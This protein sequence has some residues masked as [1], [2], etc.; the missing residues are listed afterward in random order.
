MKK[1]ILSFSAFL[2]LNFTN[3]I[4]GQTYN[5]GRIQLK[6]WLHKVWSS[7]D[8]SEISGADPV[9]KNI[10]VRV[11]T[12]NSGTYDISPS[13]LDIYFDDVG[14][15][16]WWHMGQVDNANDG[17]FLKEDVNN[18]G[19]LLFNKTYPSSIVP[20]EFQWRLDEMY[21]KDLCGGDFTYRSFQPNPFSSNFCLDG[22]DNYTSY[23]QWQT[24]VNPFRSTPAGEIGY[25]QTD[26]ADSDGGGLFGGSRDD[27]YALIFA[28]EWNWVTP[29]PPMCPSSTYRDGPINVQVRIKGVWSDS[30]YDGGINCVG[31]FAGQEELRIRTR[32]RD[33]ATNTWSS[34]ASAPNLSQP[35]P[36]WN[37]YGSPFTIFNET[38]NNNFTSVDIDFELWE[39]DGCGPDNQYNTCSFPSNA[40]ND[41]EHH[42]TGLKTIKWRDS[43]PNTW[44][45]VDFPLRNGTGKFNNWTIWLEYRWNIDPPTA[46]IDNS[47]NFGS[48][49]TYVDRILCNTT[50]T[51]ISATTEHATYYQW[52][53]ANVTG[54]ET[55][56]SGTCPSGAVWSNAPGASTCPDYVPP[57]TPGTRIYRLKVMNRSGS[58]STTNSGNRLNVAYSECVRVTYLPYAPPIVSGIC[59]GN[60]LT[61]STHVFTVKLPD[62][63]EGVANVNYNWSVSPSSN[64]SIS[65]GSTSTAS[66]TFPTPTQVLNGGNYT[67]TLTTSGGGCSTA[68]RT[69]N[70]TV[71]TEPVCNI[72]VVPGGTGGGTI[73]DPAGLEYALSIVTS[74]KN[75]IILRNGTYNLTGSA[76]TLNI[77]SHTILDG[78]YEIVGGVWRKNSN[79][80][81]TINVLGAQTT[82]ASTHHFVAANIDGRTNVYIKDL[83]ITNTRNASGTASNRGKS[84]YGVRVANSNNFHFTR[85]RINSG[86]ASNGNNGGG[87]STGSG[88]SNAENG[89]NGC[90]DCNR[91]C[92][93]GGYGGR[94]GTGGGGTSPGA[95]R[96]G[97]CGSNDQGCNGYGGS[98]GS[99][100]NGGGGGGGGVGG[101]E[102][103][104]SH[105]GGNGG[106]G[107]TGGGPGGNVSTG[108]T[109]GRGEDG[110]GASN[111]ADD[112][113]NHGGSGSS[114]GTS[115]RPTNYSLSSY[116]IPGTQADR[117][118]HG[119]GGAGGSG[120][121]AGGGEDDKCCGFD[122]SGAGGGG[123]GG[124]GQGGT[125]GYGGHGGGG[126][127]GLYAYNNSA[128]SINQFVNTSGNAGTGGS[129]G[130]GGGGGDEGS[131]GSGGSVAEAGNGG[132]GGEGGDG[133][134]GGR[135]R[136]GAN[137]LDNPLRVASGSLSVTSS[138][139]IP[140]PHM[141][142]AQTFGGCTNSEIRLTKSGGT[143]SMVSGA[144]FINDQ[145]STTSSYSTSTNN[146]FVYY[147]SQGHKNLATSST[148]VNF[149]YIGKNRENATVIDNV[150]SVCFG[151]PITIST[152]TPGAQYDFTIFDGPTV[153]S[154]GSIKATFDQATNSFYPSTPGTYTIKLRVREDCCGWSIPEYRTFIV[155]DILSN[156]AITNLGPL[157]VCNG[158]NPASLIG[159]TPTGGGGGY[160][161]QWQSTT[162]GFVWSNISGANSK[163]YNPPALSSPSVTTQY[164]YRRIVTTTTCE[165]TSN[166]YSIYVY[167]D[168]TDNTLP[169]DITA[170]A[171][172]DAANIIA[173]V[174][175]GGNGT[176]TYTWEQSINSA[177][178]TTISGANSADYDPPVLS[179]VAGAITTYDFRRIVTS[180]T[181]TNTSANY[182]ITLYPGI[183][184]NTIPDISPELYCGDVDLST[185]IGSTPTG[186][187]GSFSYAWFYRINGTSWTS[188]PGVN[189]AKDYNPPLLGLQSD[190]TTM[191]EIKRF[192]LSEGC[193]DDSPSDT[194]IVTS[195]AEN[196]V[197]TTADVFN[198]SYECNIGDWTYYTND[199]VNWDKFFFA[200]NKNG[201]TFD[202]SI[203]LNVRPSVNDVIWDVKVR[204]AYQ[205]SKADGSFVM[206][207]YWNVSLLSGSINPANPVKVR[208]Y[209]DRDE[210]QATV[211][212]RNFEMAKYPGA[213][214]GRWRWFKTI[215]QDFVPTL[216]NNGN[217]WSHFPNIVYDT[218]EVTYGIE[219]GVQYVELDNVTSFS[220]GSGGTSFGQSN[221]LLPVELISL[222][223]SARTSDI[224]IN[225]ITATEINNDYFEVQR[226]DNPIGG[227]ETIGI[228][229]GSG[230]TN[231]NKF[232]SFID[233]EVEFN[234]QYFYRLNQVDFDGT[235]EFSNVVNSVLVRGDEMFIGELLPNPASEQTTIEIVSPESEQFKLSIVNM[236]GQE[237]DFIDYKVMQGSQNVTINVN[238]L[239]PGNY[240][241]TIYSENA[242]I[243][244]RKLQVNR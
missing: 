65:G 51:T 145:N 134:A 43:P 193:A 198:F 15:H 156:N 1:I 23:N 47:G 150:T 21:E 176:F 216:I 78:N 56:P 33:N 6:V 101:P 103:G 195:P 214:P 13:G 105:R 100:R 222:T 226:S 130:F 122:G 230:T 37:I 18:K 196:V 124:G 53:V 120:G 144:A 71:V 174:P 152:P 171:G 151:E 91:G 75:H 34:F 82:S 204:P 9:Y 57:T 115:D 28:Y 191:Y 223:A 220:G 11:P 211:D 95:R 72:H 143:W 136:P 55:D 24:A 38:H 112:G 98:S 141:L 206:R 164:Q 187:N 154:P 109:S 163:D 127:F 157:E 142:T 123:G 218:S 25:V 106:W 194:F 213:T 148:Y 84:V 81:T 161:Y 42:Y 202:A 175:N 228:V 229:D 58:G 59:G 162:D 76:T 131:G 108:P 233:D 49:G 4:H 107:G 8:C 36:D 232:Y 85:I 155:D 153:S 179:L 168:I 116:F 66:I 184:N 121:G 10:R 77:R 68:S 63:I 26:V 117:G 31:G 67:I 90:D 236:L 60:V 178:F 182:R 180:T 237:I 205:G 129:G 5:D 73:D 224:E 14:T 167:P 27:R 149:I 227:F 52:E 46:S 114:W 97:S 139:T 241:L 62:D 86:N 147:T 207:R 41:D 89:Q 188:A 231:E 40:G 140:N 192:V 99:G 88:G 165:D 212:K 12:S 19:Y 61:S 132:N 209:Y 235:S 104:D 203:D 221:P 79:L 190:A 199:N 113:N 225:W 137:G 215:G 208:F 219:N 166:A 70:V 125:G 170:C 20:N 197:L 118:G 210:V 32:A 45:E 146:V 2:L 126:T 244:T 22:D 17:G 128:G 3:V 181:C 110:G 217:N 30:D 185:L 54:P 87:G 160:N 80:N 169:S 186:G 74:D 240:I 92:G 183:N 238:N 159:T 172:E 69:C 177:P 158:N 96:C 39:E 64:V 44:N 50:P 243:A 7:S 119:G 200:I 133:G 48:G 239:V 173:P 135:G 234:K 93:A 138:G 242:V 111:V 189:N 94:G 102:D 83:T 35:V 201:N 16:R 29:L